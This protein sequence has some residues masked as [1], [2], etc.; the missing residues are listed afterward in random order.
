MADQQQ[1]QEE[2]GDRPSFTSFWKRSKEA[3]SGRQITFVPSAAGQ[4][5]SCKFHLFLL[6]SW[7][8]PVTRIRY[9]I[10][11]RISSHSS[12][13]ACRFERR[14]THTRTHTATRLKQPIPPRHE[15][16]RLICHLIPSA[17]ATRW[18]H[19]VESRRWGR[20]PHVLYSYRR[21]SFLAFVYET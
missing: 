10:T 18:P 19:A 2:E 17:N 3:L 16:S 5:N 14:W 4:G 8:A 11:S 6:G 12:A 20:R 1:Q 15:H 7:C 9:H 21:T 13:S